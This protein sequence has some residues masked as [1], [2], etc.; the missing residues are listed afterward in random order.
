MHITTEQWRK[1]QQAIRDG[2]LA[3]L[4]GDMNDDAYA[5]GKHDGYEIG[6]EEAENGNKG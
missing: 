2:D 5:E 1:I 3:E 4:I 6:K